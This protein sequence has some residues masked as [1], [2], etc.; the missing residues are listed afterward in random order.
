MSQVSGRTVAE[1][2]NDGHEGSV[3]TY[4]TMGRE[5]VVL[6]VLS[7]SCYIN[8]LWGEFVFDDIIA[9]MENLDVRPETP[10][11]KVFEHDFWGQSL[12]DWQSH[13]SYRPLTTLSFRLS[14]YLAGY[15]WNEFQFHLVNV[16]LH[17]IV[18]LL[19]LATA[20]L[21]FINGPLARQKSRQATAFWA[22]AFFATH[23]IHTDAVS[24]IVSRGEML[25][26]ALLL[27]SFLAYSCGAAASSPW[28]LG[29]ET[30]DAR[31]SSCSLRS[32]VAFV[33]W[34]PLSILLAF[35]GLLC[36]EQAITVVGISVA[37]DMSVSSPLLRLL[38]ANSTPA[39]AAAPPPEATEGG[40][41]RE[42]GERAQ[43][44]EAHPQRRSAKGGRSVS[45]EHRE[46][47]ADAEAT[48]AVSGGRGGGVTLWGGW[49]LLVLR[50]GVVSAAFAGMYVWR[51]SLNGPC[52]T[53]YKTKGD[54]NISAWD[55]AGTVAPGIYSQSACRPNF[56]QVLVP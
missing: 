25:S 52:N 21:C 56:L 14:Y 28:S 49:V 53:V 17:A 41:G 34:L 38:L 19:A 18:T 8:A 33:F 23:P 29:G 30:D 26:G 5:S 39:R 54:P 55:A 35:V 44:S 1:I 3:Y 43:P 37:Y 10:L 47:E 27:L 4:A 42:G 16:I 22:A 31:P 11:T 48:G 20:R 13:K 9:V 45:E 15:H 50:V 6:I 7:T 12:I 36:K 51:M 40:A 24:S 46:E 2:G 32:V